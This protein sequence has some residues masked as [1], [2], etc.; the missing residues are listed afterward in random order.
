MGDK[1]IE[2]FDEQKSESTDKTE[3]QS[4][5]SES[6]LL[7]KDSQNLEVKVEVLPIEEAEPLISEPSLTTKNIEDSECIEKEALQKDFSK[8]KKSK[9]TNKSSK[10]YDLF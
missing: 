3:K 2:S 8:S 1:I 4:F 7:I 9:K 5:V 6:H 10:I